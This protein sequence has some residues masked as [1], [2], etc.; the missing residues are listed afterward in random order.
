MKEPFPKQRV[1]F[2]QIANALLQDKQLS[3]K[4]KGLYAYLYSKPDTWD[5]AVKRIARDGLDGVRAISAALKELERLGYLVR[6]RQVNGRMTYKIYWSPKSQ[7]RNVP[8]PQCAKTAT[9]SNQE[10]ESNKELE[11]NKENA[12]AEQSSAGTSL[13]ADA[14]FE[15][16][17]EDK[18][19][20]MTFE[21]FVRMCRSSRYRHINI[22]GEH[23]AI[24]RPANHTRGEWR[25]FGRRN[26]RAAQ[27][28][29]PYNDNQIARATDALL[30]D[31]RSPSNKKGYLREWGLETVIKYFDYA[32]S[33]E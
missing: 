12:S 23:A 32:N 24:L 26:F 3:F 30:K 14:F 29:Q 15:N 2:A 16:K 28:L 33:H 4:A 9:L 25:K 18:G 27:H 22:I 8:K 6:T 11:I 10:D 1:P 19:I 20:P 5:F 17:S 31:V 7:N 13:E 21:E